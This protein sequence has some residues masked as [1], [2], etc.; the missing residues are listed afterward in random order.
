MTVVRIGF[1]AKWTCMYPKEV[2]NLVN[3]AKSYLTAV[4]LNYS[5]KKSEIDGKCS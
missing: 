4:N 1:I 5:F 3:I 2:N